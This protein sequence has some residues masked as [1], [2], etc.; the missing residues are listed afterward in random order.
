MRAFSKVLGLTIS[1]FFLTHTLSSQ[2]FTPSSQSGT[3]T[4]DS[5][6]FDRAFSLQKNEVL[7]RDYVD[8]GL[9]A[10][11]LEAGFSVD[12]A[13]LFELYRF[14]EDPFNPQYDPDLSIISEL[15]KQ[16]KENRL[17]KEQSVDE[18]N[19]SFLRICNPDFPENYS[20]FVENE[21]IILSDEMVN[22]MR[23]ESI[24]TEL[25]ALFEN[26]IPNIYRSNELIEQALFEE[27]RLL[28]QVLIASE[29][30]TI[31]YTNITVSSY[32]KMLQEIKINAK[33]KTA[34]PE[35]LYPELRRCDSSLPAEYEV[36][37]KED[38]LVISQ[39]AADCFLKRIPRNARNRLLNTWRQI[40]PD[41]NEEDS[42]AEGPIEEE[43]KDRGL[44]ET[45]SP[46]PKPVETPYKSA[47]NAGK[48]IFPT[49][50]LIDATAQFL[51]ERTKEELILTFFDQFQQRIDSIIELRY[52]FTNTYSLLQNREFFHV[53][54][55]GKTWK[56]AF[57]RDLRDLPMSMERMI[58]ESPRFL[59]LK[60]R[61][62]YRIFLMAFHFQD[63]Y[64]RSELPSSYILDKFVNLSQ[65]E[66][67]TYMDSALAVIKHN[68][69]DFRSDLSNSES[70]Y[71]RTYQTD[72]N[73][74]GEQ[75]FVALQY[76]KSPDYYDNFYLG[77]GKSSY[78]AEMKKHPN[79]IYQTERAI[80]EDIKQMDKELQTLSIPKQP[81]GD[82]LIREAQL[83]AH[84]EYLYQKES[85]LRQAADGLNKI[86]RIA[87]SLKYPGNPEAVLADKDYQSTSQLIYAASQLIPAIESRSPS[88]IFVHS[89]QALQP[90]FHL[91]SKQETKSIRHWNQELEKVAT[92]RIANSPAK[93]SLDQRHK[94]LSTNIEKSLKRQ[95]QLEASSK[96]IAFYGGFMIDIFYAKTAPEIKGLL[97]KYA[98]PAGSYRIKRRSQLS[99]ELGA[100]PSL[101]GGREFIVNN[102]GGKNV[103]W[104]S[105]VSAPVGLTL[106][107]P[108]KK[109]RTPFDPLTEE[110][111]FKGSKLKGNS[112]SGH[113]FSLFF[114]VVDLGA[115]FSFRWNE[116]NNIALP[117]EITW[118]QLLSP[119]L[120]AVWG[121]KNKPVS[122]SFGGQYVPKLRSITLAG[123]EVSQFDAFRVGFN[124][125]IDIPIFSLFRK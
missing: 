58:N 9:A 123:N 106:S 112:Y 54:T 10:A 100:Y 52:L 116:G 101:Y 30:S 67:G 88:K 47:I 57:E 66:G 49:T 51:V 107:W 22:C 60:R 56:T 72:L 6:L 117:E 110:K 122:L 34:L 82:T 90:I 95:S 68:L 19:Y 29:D 16:L 109:S 11:Y 12:T 25:M 38:S 37:V 53:P 85:A 119:G 45:V 41:K 98:L 43:T 102:P 18:F 8:N 20:L 97:Y 3:Q 84:S 73:T 124:L 40:L 63:W 74:R 105:G 71:A 61:S 75:L 125:A 36:F 13:K 7:V 94:R 65:L 108:I 15:E 27:L 17:K 59:F 87:Y 80:I 48:G 44:E 4:E 64:T 79:R 99:I 81:L 35:R 96:H 26:R 77:N 91:A 28:Q 55:L 50:Q 39:T 46:E 92:L 31:N 114:P 118:Q 2:N 78:A 42:K 104:V 14:Y 83:L 115:P 70:W 1:L 23:L 24:R 111:S 5:V 93:D 69:P 121:M 113:S 21:F 86:Q 32:G 33:V 103:G 76:H 62:D 120:F 89:L